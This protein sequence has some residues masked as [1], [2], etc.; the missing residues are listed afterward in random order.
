MIIQ[1]P[2]SASIQLR[3]L[4][5]SVLKN[6]IAANTATTMPTIMASHMAAVL[7][8]EKPITNGEIISQRPNKTFRPLA[9]LT[10]LSIK[11]LLSFPLS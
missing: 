6:R 10:W 2:S 5:E 4:D 3:A 11:M 7:R 8:A 1:M 9:T